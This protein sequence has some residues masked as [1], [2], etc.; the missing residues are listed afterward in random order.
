MPG[1]QR[2]VAPFLGILKHIPRLFKL[3][4]SL[5]E[6]RIVVADCQRALVRVAAQPAA[7]AEVEVS[8]E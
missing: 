8:A 3:T 6:L 1:T 5:E 2:L 4:L 7:S